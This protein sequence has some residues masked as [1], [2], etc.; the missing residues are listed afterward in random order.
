MAA[1]TAAVI[2]A[3]AGAVFSALNYLAPMAADSADHA[4]SVACNPAS[5]SVFPVGNS[6]VTCTATD[7]AGRSAVTSFVVLVE[8]PAAPVTPAVIADTF[9]SSLDSWSYKEIP[10]TKYISAYCGP[11]DETEASAYLLSHSTEHGGSAH[12]SNTDRCW[13]G[14]AG[15]IKSFDFPAGYNTLEIDLDYRS[16][17]GVFPGVGQVNNVQVMVTDSSDMVIHTAEMYR[18]ARSS[19]LTDTA[20]QDYTVSVFGI[21]S[22]DCPC[23]MFVYLRDGWSSQW[24]QKFYMDDVT[25]RATNT[26]SLLGPDLVDSAPDSLTGS[27]YSMEQKFAR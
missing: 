5:G 25:L 10:D 15:A 27:D 23:K 4:L 2:L 6:T 16:L 14:W 3:F 18:G 21:S 7:G 19:G 12:I 13:F 26:A 11:E 8:Q 9:D 20:W 22:S 24:H 17:A 1:L